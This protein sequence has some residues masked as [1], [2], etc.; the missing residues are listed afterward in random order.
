[1]PSAA[2]AAL[3]PRL[4]SAG[5][6]EEATDILEE[7]ILHRRVK[8]DTLFEVSVGLAELEDK[9]GSGTPTQLTS[10]CPDWDVP[11]I[12]PDTSPMCRNLPT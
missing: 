9:V 8:G 1:M 7:W 4:A 3:A 11:L 2:S 5:G 12:A 6:D 10:R